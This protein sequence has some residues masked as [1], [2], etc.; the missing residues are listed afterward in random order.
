MPNEHHK[1]PAF[2]PFDGQVNG[3]A[4]PTQSYRDIMR[5]TSRCDCQ[6]CRRP[7]R[8]LVRFLLGHS[9][10]HPLLVGSA[11]RHVENG[12]LA[13][14]R[15]GEV[16]STFARC[17]RPGLIAM[18]CNFVATAL[19]LHVV[20][21]PP[22]RS[23]FLPFF[24]TFS[25]APKEPA[26][27]IQP[28]RR[29]GDAR[30]RRHLPHA[31]EAVENKQIL[32]RVASVRLLAQRPDGVSARP[33]IAKDVEGASIGQRERGKN[34]NAAAILCP[35]VRLER[36]AVHRQVHVALN[37]RR[38]E[39]RFVVAEICSANNLRK[40]IAQPAHRLSRRSEFEAGLSGCGYRAARS[41]EHAAGGYDKDDA[42]GRRAHLHHGAVGGGL[43]AEAVA[44]AARGRTFNGGICTHATGKLLLEEGSVRAE[45]KAEP[46]AHVRGAA[47][48]RGESAVEK[49]ELQMHGCAIGHQDC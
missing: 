36:K 19:D 32:F 12:N 22:T 27:H 5:S 1:T 10:G 25:D 21:A 13:G 30:P 17:T 6:E 45:L 16:R 14:C 39:G 48:K 11:N 29:D 26:I 43:A 2:L 9:D 44:E 20:S 40:F 37:R 24:G 23:C 15:N 3:D 18:P 42:L 38:A 4:P 47:G 49:A 33:E 35:V 28:H 46:V 41:G 8:Q 7:C 34:V 31:A